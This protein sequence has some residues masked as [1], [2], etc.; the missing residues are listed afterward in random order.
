M[1]YIL[2]YEWLLDIFAILH[3]RA[4]NFQIADL[5]IYWSRFNT[6]TF[7]NLSLTVGVQS[8]AFHATSRVCVCVQYVCLLQ[9]IRVSVRERSSDQV[10]KPVNLAALTEWVGTFPQDLLNKMD[11]VRVNILGRVG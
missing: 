11:Q 6:H 1:S 7:W 2:S 5:T 8:S 3:Q 4:K 10:V 9:G